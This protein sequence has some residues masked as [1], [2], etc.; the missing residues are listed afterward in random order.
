MRARDH[1]TPAPPSPGRP[2]EP[3]SLCGVLICNFFGRDTATSG[4]AAGGLHHRQFSEVGLV[5][6]L[7]G[8]IFLLYKLIILQIK[9]KHL[10]AF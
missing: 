5:I 2:R 8:L 7:I 4:D 9:I 6:G 10:V 3:P 1:E